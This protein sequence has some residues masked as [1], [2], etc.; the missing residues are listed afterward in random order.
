MIGERIGTQK[1][2]DPAAAEIKTII[3]TE[4]EKMVASKYI[5]VLDFIGKL[6]SSKLT[7]TEFLELLRAYSHVAFIHNGI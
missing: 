2:E 3:Q 7:T 4:S 1:K 6:P 5:M